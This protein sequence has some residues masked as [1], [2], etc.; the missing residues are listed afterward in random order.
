MIDF[1]RAVLRT[2]FLP[3]IFLAALAATSPSASAAGFTFL[4]AGNFMCPQ[5]YVRM[6]E[7]IVDA[8]TPKERDAMVIA[9]VF[10][11]SCTGASAVASEIV[12][13]EDRRSPNGNGYSC[14]HLYDEKGPM[15]CALNQYVTDIETEIA[16]RSGD[17]RILGEGPG[18]IKV[19]CL[20]GGMVSMQKTPRGWERF[21][22]IFPKQMEFPR[23]FSTDR[24]T[25]LREGCRGFD[26][27]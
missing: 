14:F 3:A 18:G 12:E 6:L 1:V 17:Y 9:A 10:S 2:G 13:V 20:E 26:Y 27:R 11:G 15:N 19:S 16:Q 25:A 5:E 7:H 8:E 23:A 4:R 24:E 22:M 21:S